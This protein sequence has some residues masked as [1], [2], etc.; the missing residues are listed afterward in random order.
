MLENAQ[1]SLK[2][3]K[4]LIN[5]GAKTPG[6]TKEELLPLRAYLDRCNAW[7][8]DARSLLSRRTRRELY[9][10]DSLI[11]ILGEMIKKGNQ[12]YFENFEIDRLRQ[13][14]DDL[15]DYQTRLRSLLLR[16]RIVTLEQWNG[17]KNL[18]GTLFVELD[19]AE[20]V[21]DWIN[22]RRRYQSFEKILSSHKPMD[23]DEVIEM[24]GYLRDYGIHSNDP[25]NV[26]LKA[27]KVD[28]EQWRVD[29]I[30][31]LKMK[32]I[33]EEELNSFV[34]RAS[35]DCAQIPD[36]YDR[37]VALSKKTQS[38][39][40]AAQKLLATSGCNDT[41]GS[42]DALT[43]DDVIRMINDSQH[44]PADESAESTPQPHGSLIERLENLL[45]DID[46]HPVKPIEV[47][48]LK[49]ELN[50]VQKWLHAAKK[51]FVNRNTPKSLSLSILDAYLRTS[52]CTRFV[53]SQESRYCICRST[54][55][56]CLM[57]CLF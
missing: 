8:L 32:R 55:E 25:V 28:A 13:W 39:R 40:N 53:D 18:A 11:Q 24:L 57:V 34:Q 47:A 56:D 45:I 48:P 12:L 4:T 5:Q 22:F 29:A 50:R 38:W 23:Y 49:A 51:M 41:G 30:G 16:P 9:H 21:E 14:L 1:P 26:K 54:R 52:D 19:E 15:Q 43:V 27:L 7:L 37:V 20:E 36:I 46:G 3:I 33:T 35:K 2:L 42:I 10:S 31:L 6:I 44:L 17:I